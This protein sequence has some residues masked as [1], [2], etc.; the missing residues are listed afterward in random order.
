MEGNIPQVVKYV[1]TSDG[2]NADDFVEWSS[3][4]RVSLSCHSKY[5]VRIVRGLQRPSE[6]ENDQATAHEV[7]DDA[8]H[9]LSSILYFTTSSPCFSVVRRFEGK[10]R[11]NRVGHVQDAWAALREKFHD[12]SRESLRAAHREMETVKLRWD[13][14]LDDFLPKEH[15]CH[16]HLN[17]AT[18]KESPLDRQ[19]RD[20]VLQCLPPE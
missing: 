10:T 11:R 12:C 20:I 7:W 1:S 15:R 14:D 3:K 8:D 9:N 4:L 17:S 16:D 2:K 5:L 18:A 19:C 6:L 13:E